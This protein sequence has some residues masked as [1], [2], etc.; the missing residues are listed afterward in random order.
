[1]DVG[2]GDGLFARLAWPGKQTWGIDINPTEVQRAQ[3]T[4]AYSTLVCGNICTVDLPKAF[5]GSAIANCSLEHVTD[6]AGALANIRSALRPGA[7][8]VLIVPTPAWAS[9]LMVPTLLSKL[10]MVSLAR[11]YGDGLDQIFRHVHL[12]DD[13]T[14][15]RHLKTVGFEAVEVR[16][17]AGRRVSYTF[18]L[19]LLPSLVGYLN[20]RLTGR[21]VLVPG[22][23][24]FSADAVRGFLNSVAS[25]MTESTGQA[26]EYLIYCRA[27]P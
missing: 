22:L 4:Q 15:A 20:K 25:H 7:P 5:F 8:F 12:Y 13:A 6:L 26:A 2:C 27:A 24:P 14:W 9:D 17:V 21:W 23:R 11:A 19:M 1:L 16:P 10:G 18:D 3:S